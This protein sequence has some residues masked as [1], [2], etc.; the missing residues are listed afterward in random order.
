MS[1]WG[2]PLISSISGTGMEKKLFPFLSVEHFTHLKWLRRKIALFSLVLLSTHLSPEEE[3]LVVLE[4]LCRSPSSHLSHPSHPLFPL[5]FSLL[6]CPFTQSYGMPAAGSVSCWGL[7][8]TWQEEQDSRR[9]AS[10]IFQ[11]ELL[12]MQTMVTS[13]CLMKTWHCQFCLSM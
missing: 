9:I 12:F 3:A 5:G 6:V 13:A 2:N 10:S 1:K 4:V 7:A 11:D 8:S